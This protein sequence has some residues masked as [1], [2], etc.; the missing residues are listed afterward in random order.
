MVNLP[1]VWALATAYVDLALSVV[2]W[3]RNIYI[4]VAK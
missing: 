3:A 2:S 4:H 1:S